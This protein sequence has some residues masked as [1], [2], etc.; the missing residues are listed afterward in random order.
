MVQPAISKLLATAAKPL[1][2][3]VSAWWDQLGLL[4]ENGLL[5][6]VLFPR[7]ADGS[8]CNWSFPALSPKGFLETSRSSNQV[9]KNF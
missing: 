7:A 6:C 1:P 2:T 5:K 9:T 4:L 3:K 8:N